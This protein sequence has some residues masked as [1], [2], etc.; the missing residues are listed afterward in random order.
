MPL[1][2]EQENVLQFL[3][4]NTHDFWTPERANELTRPFGFEAFTHEERADYKSPKGLRLKDNAKS[5]V[6]AS[7]LD[8]SGQI[9]AKTGAEAGSFIGRGFQVRANC[10]AIREK[11]K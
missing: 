1:T 5:A 2:P 11:L 6:G 10:D 4:A 9:V 3:A 8:I 7:S